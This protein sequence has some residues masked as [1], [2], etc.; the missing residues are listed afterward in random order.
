MLITYGHKKS[1]LKSQE[2]KERHAQRPFKNAT[3]AKRRKLAKE[4]GRE[5]GT[6]NVARPRIAENN[7]SPECSYMMPFL[8]QSSSP[9]R[10]H[11]HHHLSQQQQQT[12]LMGEKLLLPSL[13]TWCSLEAL[14]SVVCANM[15]RHCLCNSR[16]RCKA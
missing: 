11:Q 12:I 7:V 1:A 16:H 15:G 5:I 9:T 10:T 4:R 6:G 13:Q 2:S 14:A 3:T 8:V